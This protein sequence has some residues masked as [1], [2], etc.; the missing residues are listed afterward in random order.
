MHQRRINI[1]VRGFRNWNSK[2]ENAAA[3]PVTYSYMIKANNTPHILIYVHTYTYAVCM[4]I[5]YTKAKIQEGGL[6]VN[7]SWICRLICISKSSLWSSLV[8]SFDNI[9]HNI[10][11]P[12]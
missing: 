7:N 5:N 2:K 8:R 6:I 4:Y 11:N 3:S 12:V 1:V 10:I 9:L